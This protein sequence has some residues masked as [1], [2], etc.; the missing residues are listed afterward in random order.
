MLAHLILHI[1]DYVTTAILINNLNSNIEGNFL[2][3]CIIE[4]YGL[5]GLGIF[6]LVILV[7]ITSIIVYM[8]YKDK[9]RHGFLLLSIILTSIAITISTL[10]MLKLL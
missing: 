6:K 1:G 8:Y 7:I 4:S 2:A 5:I 9:V 3:H 10:G